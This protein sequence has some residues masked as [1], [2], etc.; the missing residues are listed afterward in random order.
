[1]A[2][3]KKIVKVRKDDKGNVTHVIY[4]DGKVET[5]NQAIKR[6]QKGGIANYDAVV[7]KNG[8]P[9]LR[10]ARGEKRALADLPAETVAKKKRT[11]G[12][13]KKKK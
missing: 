13:R 6:A 1:M 2:E 5:L 12:S 3:A 9:Y 4:D 11:C 10:K 8:K 7:P